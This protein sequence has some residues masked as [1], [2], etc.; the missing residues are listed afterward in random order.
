[1]RGVLLVFAFLSCSAFAEQSVSNRPPIE[2]LVIPEGFPLETHIVKTV[3]GYNLGVY[4]IPHGRFYTAPPEGGHRPV[5]YL[6]HG[7]LD[8]SATF[9][10]NGASGS[11]GFLLAESGCDV[12]LGNSRGNSYSDF[13]L[14]QNLDH[15]QFWDFSLDELV[16]YDLPATLEYVLNESGA[17]TLV[18]IGHSQG[19]AIAHALFSRQH[20]ITQ[21]IAIAFMMSPVAYV[22]HI[23]CAFL[24]ALAVFGTD[25]LVAS[26]GYHQFLPNQES[27][28]KVMGPFCFMT[29]EACSDILGILYGYNPNNLDPAGWDTYFRYTP[30]GASVK[31]MAHWAQAVRNRR[32]SFRMFDYGTKCWSWWKAKPL[33]CNQLMY[34]SRS[35][36]NYDLRDIRV[37]MVY[38][39]GGHD[40]LA[41]L[42]DVLRLKEKLAPGVLRDEHL[43]LDYTHL[44]FIWGIDAPEKIYST[45]IDTIHT[46]H[47]NG[48]LDAREARIVV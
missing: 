20:P 43:E 9:L 17:E 12:W 4:R 35:P 5:V 11:L 32:D 37:P 1:M 28:H 39:Y 18:Y 3:D 7:L 8:T 25:D 14:Q 26:L 15:D 10:M 41:D 44:D 38:F 45:M 33:R 36:P 22:Q 27:L 34:K 46:M 30:A 42:V 16:Q 23:T 47:I 13:A 24:R 2:D 21:R 29:G 31:L 40:A 48:S 19:T 6:Q